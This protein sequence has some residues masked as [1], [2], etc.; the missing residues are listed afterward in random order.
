MFVP[1][2]YM[3][4]KLNYWQYEYTGTNEIFYWGS[5]A[6]ATDI[7]VGLIY[8]LPPASAHNDATK[9]GVIE[10]EICAFSQALISKAWKVLDAEVHLV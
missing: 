6:N 5:L 10:G 4:S 8:P 2:C 1:T 9:L 7:G 3:R